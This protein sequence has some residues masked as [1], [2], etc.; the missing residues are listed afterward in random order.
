MGVLAGEGGQQSDFHGGLL[1]SK[2]G[3]IRD[4][5]LRSRMT[6]KKGDRQRRKEERTSDVAQSQ[7]ESQHPHLPA[8]TP[9]GLLSREITGEVDFAR[10]REEP[11]P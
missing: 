8:A 6:Q 3:K 11:N 7:L 9:A 2:E 4:S 10:T 1:V 5:S